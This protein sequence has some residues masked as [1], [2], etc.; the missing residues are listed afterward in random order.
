MHPL[1]LSIGG[2][3][4]TLPAA[5]LAA[6]LLLSAADARAQGNAKQAPNNAEQDPQFRLRQSIQWQDGPAVG[7]LGDVAEIKIPEGY[8]LTDRAGAAAWAELNQNVAN[9]DELGVLRP[10]NAEGWFIIF[11]Y[12][13]SGHV[14]DSEKA[15]LDADAIL[16]SLQAGNDA[17]NAMRR[18][19]GWAEVSVVG[20]INPPAY[21]EA[22]HHLAWAVRGRCRGED[23]ANYNTRILG[24]TGVMS[25]NLVVDPQEMDRVVPTVKTLLAGFDFSSGHKYAEWRSGDKLAA[26]GLTGLITGGAALAAAKS[27]LLAKLGLVIAKAGKAIVVG[28]LALAAGIWKVVTRIF[29]RKSAAE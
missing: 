12:D 27:G 16:K 6:G 3:L 15:D 25:A 11:S 18:S 13:N 8:Q 4:A 14:P 7:K 26:Y 28:I 2:R 22:S 10:T 29:G 24:R 23:I 19:K 17:A 5:V 1:L 9:P 21:D 20:W